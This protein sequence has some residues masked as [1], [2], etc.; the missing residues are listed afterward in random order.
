MK[1]SHSCCYWTGAKQ[2]PG[3]KWRKEQKSRVDMLQ[4]DELMLHR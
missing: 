1:V 2:K 3:E 4:D